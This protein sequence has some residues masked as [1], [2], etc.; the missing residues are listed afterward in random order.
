MELHGAHS[1]H[2]AKIHNGPPTAQKTKAQSPYILFPFL[3][4]R[5]KEHIFDFQTQSSLRFHALYPKS[6]VTAGSKLR[7][8]TVLGECRD[9]PVRLLPRHRMH[10][11]LGNIC[12]CS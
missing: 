6:R 3:V 1:L 7:T 5:M 8:T 12:E 2:E 11:K 4:Y 9:S 10:A